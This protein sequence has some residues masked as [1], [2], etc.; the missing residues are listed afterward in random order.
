MRRLSSAFTAFHQQTFSQGWLAIPA[1]VG[2]PGWLLPSRGM[3]PLWPHRLPLLPVPGVSLLR[4]RKR[5]AARLERIE[6]LR[7]VPQ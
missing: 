1:F 5:L 6:A 4:P 2:G 7:G 3:P